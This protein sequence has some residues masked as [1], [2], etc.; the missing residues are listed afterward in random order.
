MRRL[1]ILATLLF[2]GCSIVSHSRMEELEKKTERVTVA[3]EEVAKA[4][5]EMAE[6]VKRLETKAREV[7]DR[8]L[9]YLP[10]GDE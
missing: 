2:V 5:M 6:V 4:H 7:L 1:L 9:S 8:I 3:A 10:K